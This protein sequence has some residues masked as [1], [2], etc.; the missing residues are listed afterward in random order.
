[1][2]VMGWLSSPVSSNAP[3]PSASPPPNGPVVALA[4]SG[5]RS[6]PPPLQ[7]GA[8]AGARSVPVF[9]SGLQPLSYCSHCKHKVMCWLDVQH[10]AVTASMAAVA[11]TSTTLP[12]S[13]MN[14]VTGARVALQQVLD[15]QTTRLR[16]SYATTLLSAC[17]HSR[18]GLEVDLPCVLLAQ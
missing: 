14:S 16:A 10:A 5:R 2:R 7:G 18:I 1:M 15:A 17:T 9:H 6:L 12:S 11:R 8:S 3:P 13:C 4:A